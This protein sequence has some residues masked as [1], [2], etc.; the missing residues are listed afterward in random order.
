M[1]PQTQTLLTDAFDQRRDWLEAPHDKAFRLFNGFA[2]GLPTLALD[3]YGSTLVVHDH[4]PEVT[5]D[6]ALVDE[7]VALARKAAPFVSVVLWKVRHAQAPAARAGTVIVGE[8][9]GLGRRVKEDGVA[10]KLD[11]TLNRDTSLYLDTRS[12]RRWAKAHCSG[13]QVLNTFAY[14]GSL[15]IAALA[16]GAARVLHTDLD[17]DFL[18]LAKDSTAMNG[19]PIRKPDFRAGDF[20]DVMGKLK[21]EDQLFDVVFVDP[22]YFS[23]T[24]QGVVNVAE[25]LARLVNKARP[26]VAHDGRLV[27]VNN[28]VFVSGQAFLA[29]V[30]QLCADGFLKLEERLDVDPDFA[31]YPSTRKPNWPQDPAPFN[32]STKVVVL[33]ATRKDG[34]GAGAKA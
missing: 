4:S 21:R 7:V 1:S 8:P 19:W 15:G 17:A 31:G 9:K 16:G 22:P 32:H 28:A 23:R 34:R 18:Q 5:G 11:L 3:V 25:E 20:F 30:E 13:K 10:Y 27:L 12:L 24:E 6:R 14:T 26:L 29:T 33:R 2:E